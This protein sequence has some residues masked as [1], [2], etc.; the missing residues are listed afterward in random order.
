M[1]KGI[2]QQIE[3]N[4][5]RAF[6][7]HVL[8]EEHADGLFRCWV[9]KRTDSIVYSFRVVTAPGALIVYGDVGHHILYRCEDMLP[10]IRG[11]I[12]SRDY[13]LEKLM[14]DSKATTQ[15]YSEL[16]DEYFDDELAEA[17]KAI[18]EDFDV[19]H[20]EWRLKAVQVAKE[21]W[22]DERSYKEEDELPRVIYDI[23]T[24]SD[25]DGGLGEDGETMQSFY[26][27][28]ADVLWSYFCLACFVW[29]YE[30]K[31]QEAA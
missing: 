29:L 8:I 20:H 12:G 10:W 26:F 7:D 14:A 25:K 30:L 11:S 6:E 3:E 28:T 22:E 2:A 1:K 13:V 27:W 19:E 15:F 31:E 18:D 17:Q 4:A 24:D 21:R 16:V 9:C 23:V 5:K